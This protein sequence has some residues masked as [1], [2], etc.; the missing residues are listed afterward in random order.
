MLLRS[1]TIFE[2]KSTSRHVQVNSG[3]VMTV[4]V[5]LLAWGLMTKRRKEGRPRSVSFPVWAIESGWYRPATWYR[6]GALQLHVPGA[7]DPWRRRTDAQ[8]RKRTYPRPRPHRIHFTRKQQP[9]FHLCAREIGL[10]Q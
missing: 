1:I 6:R 8:R 7:N 4:T 10:D 5:R 3:G 2:A 9:A